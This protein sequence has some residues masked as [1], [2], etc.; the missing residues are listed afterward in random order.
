MFAFGQRKEF[1]IV[2]T[3]GAFLL[4]VLKIL[5]QPFPQLVVGEFCTLWHFYTLW[6]LSYVSQSLVGSARYVVLC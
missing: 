2:Y 6:C 3:E 4:F 5:M 1:G